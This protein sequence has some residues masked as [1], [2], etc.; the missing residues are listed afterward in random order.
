MSVVLLEAAVGG[1]LV[2]WASGVWGAV[3][4]GFFLLAGA[5][6]GLCALGA[7]AVAG[8][9]LRRVPGPAAVWAL[10]GLALLAA[11]AVLWQVL[12]LAQRPR[13]ARLVGIAA[14]VV[15]VVVLGLVG[16]VRGGHVA[17][18]ILE[19]MLGALFLGST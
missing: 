9:G 4:R 19:L 15:G 14:T 2:L 12:L 10:S 7:W 6:T 1:L 13:A 11:L 3:H 16:A 5:T 17:R 18:G 8:L